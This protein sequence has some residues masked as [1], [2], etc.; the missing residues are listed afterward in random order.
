[1]IALTLRIESM[2]RRESSLRGAAMQGSAREA[3]YF[4]RHRDLKGTEHAFD[5]D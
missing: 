2:T 3:S 4:L 1:M 5:H